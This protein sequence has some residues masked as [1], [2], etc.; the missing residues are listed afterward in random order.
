[1]TTMRTVRVVRDVVTSGT[2]KRRNDTLNKV[3]TWLLLLDELHAG[4]EMVTVGVQ[5]LPT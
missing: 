2:S 3:M 4:Q 1:M 5:Q